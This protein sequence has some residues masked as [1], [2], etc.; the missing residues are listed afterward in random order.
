M[1]VV[2]AVTRAPLAG[3]QVRTLTG[4]VLLS[5][6]QGRFQV[7]SQGCLSLVSVAVSATGYLATRMVRVEASKTIEL[8]R[9]RPVLVLVDHASNGHIAARLEV[10]EPAQHS[11]TLLVELTA[12]APF[13][14]D[15]VPRPAI[16]TIVLAGDAMFPYMARSLHLTPTGKD[17][18]QLRAESG[19]IDVTVGGGGILYA[20]VLNWR[21]DGLVQ[22]GSETRSLF[23]K[24]I[25]SSAILRVAPGTYQVEGWGAGSCN[26]RR[27]VELSAD[28]TARVQI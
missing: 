13:A 28:Y 26:C 6:A 23:A 18:L 3:A 15:S 1:T 4:D 21:L 20:E 8:F 24:A 7:N 22:K 17:T 27:R 16:L 12:G 10:T 9:H 19:W 11:R 14:L 5:D 2:D 25:N